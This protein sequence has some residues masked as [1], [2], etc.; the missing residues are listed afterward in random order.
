MVYPIQPGVPQPSVSHTTL[1]V[2][3]VAHVGRMFS[4]CKFV[5]VATPTGTCVQARS[6]S[7]VR[8]R[9]SD[10]RICLLSSPPNMKAVA[11]ALLC[12]ARLPHFDGLHES[13]FQQVFLAIPLHG[14]NRTTAALSHLA[15]QGY[16]FLHCIRA[17]LV[18]I[19]RNLERR[20]ILKEAHRG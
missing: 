20:E 1:P 17:R 11:S 5:A 10:I 6:R 12:V 14:R 13:P 7:Q 19:G 16:S 8:V 18:N 15:R 4:C 9:S 3:Y 2:V